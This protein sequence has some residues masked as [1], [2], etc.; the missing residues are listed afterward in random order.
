MRKYTE[1]QKQKHL[2]KFHNLINSGH[3]VNDAA[4]KVGVNRIT[5]RAWE[6][7]NKSSAEVL[8]HE[9][10]EQPIKRS[11]GRPKKVKNS[12][13]LIAV[14]GSATEISEIIRGL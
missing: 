1:A 13:K 10:V 8:M 12:N 14:I 9:V 11:V 5:L 4:D 3:N 6:A 7:K 2:T